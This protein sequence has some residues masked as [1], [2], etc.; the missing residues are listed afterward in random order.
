[1]SWFRSDTITHGVP[2]PAKVKMATPGIGGRV[3]RGSLLA[4]SASPA[5][6]SKWANGAGL[7]HAISG[8]A[9]ETT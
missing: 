9:Q 6:R 7:R 5:V 8:S 3:R 2:P 4:V 1:M